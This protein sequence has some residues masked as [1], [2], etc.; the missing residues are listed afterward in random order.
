[1]SK[2]IAIIN[3]AD[4]PAYI[5]NADRAK[6][7]NAEALQGLTFGGQPSIRIRNGKFRLKESGSD[8]VV[9]KPSE[10]VDGMYLPAIIVGV[11]GPMN[12]AY[13]AT[14]F[15]PNQDEPSTPDCFSFDGKAPDKSVKE[16]MCSNCAACPQNAFGS[17][18]NQAGQP[19]KGKACSDSKVM[20]LLYKGTIY[21]MKVPPA[22]LKNLATYLR[23]LD[24]HGIPYPYAVTHISF[25]EESEY[26][27]L[28][29]R[30]GRYLP[31][32]KLAQAE[33]FVNSRETY[34]IM[35]PVA[36][37]PSESKALPAPA[38]AAAPAPVEEAKP[39]EVVEPEAKPAPKAVKAKAAAEEPAPKAAGVKAP[40][41]QEEI[42]A[43]M[44]L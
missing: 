26:S 21:S 20:A 42:D 40:P 27:V 11:R 25:D 43:I 41:T 4:V 16:P 9:L 33:E 13:Y 34:E 10:L 12:K 14:K 39:V 23:E 31:A 36:Y 24:R 18:R 32:D 35:H 44:G 28:T 3:P 15:D 2:D 30:V 29:F 8:D 17:G 37:V 22:S 19:T 5:V 6:E 7:M 38:K 1:M